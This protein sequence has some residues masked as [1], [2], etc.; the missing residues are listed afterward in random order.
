VGNIFAMPESNTPPS[1][2]KHL[3]SRV[4]GEVYSDPV[5]LGLYA[6]DASNYQIQPLA[7]VVPRGE[8]DV[9]AAI[10]L[11]AEEGVAMLPRGGGTSLAGQAVA[12]AMVIDF[13][14]Y[15]NRILEVCAEER[16]ARV[17]PGLV[18]DELNAALLPTG[19]HFA[20]DPATGSRANLGGMMGTNAS[21]MRSV[22]YGRTSDHVLE[23]RVLLADGSEHLW[24]SL[25]PRD[26]ERTI[27][28]GGRTGELLGSFQGIIRRH[29][30]EIRARYP[31]I[32]RCVAG[33]SLDAFV[34]T[35]RWNLSKLMV[36]SEGTLASMVEAKVNLEPLP[37][38]SCLCVA[39]FG[40]LLE[41]IDAVEPI[42]THRPSAVEL[43]DRVTLNL[44]R[45]N[46]AVAAYCDALDGDPAAVLVVEF[47]GHDAAETRRQA[48]E[49]VTDL[50]G[51]GQGYAFPI[52]T[53]PAAQARI[54][55]LRK[56][57]LGILLALKGKRKPIPFM[58][59]AAVPVAVL[60]K[61]IGQVQ[62]ICRRHG[63]DVALYA[64]ASV[65]LIHVRPILD[66]RQP[67]DIER[68]KS[69]ADEAFEL[70]KDYGG[71]WSGEH[72]D[73]LVRSPFLERFYG[74]RL[75]QAFRE[76]KRLF[77]PRGLMNP[78]HI[79]DPEPMDH[80]LR[81]GPDYRV[82]EMP[83][84]Y[85]F[86][87]EGGFTEA[88]HLCNGVG[89]CRKTL[90]GTMCPSY[91]ATRDEAHS[92]R[93]R[94]N[95]LRLAMSGQLGPDGMTSRA[96]YDVLALCLSC[97]ACKT[98]CPSNV[99]MA[100]LKGEFM[101]GYHDRHGASLRDRLTAGL[102]ARSARLAGPWAPLV[103]RLQGSAPFRWLLEQTAGFSRRRVAPPYAREPFPDWFA[104][105]PSVP[106]G[107]AEKRVV[108][109]DDTY[110]N[111]FEPHIGQSAVALLESC[112]YSVTLARAG[113]CQ[114]P[115]LS[116]GFLRRAARDGTA[117]LR[118]LDRYIQ[119]G[120]K[121]LVCE[122]SCA[123]ALTDDLP[124][125]AD[126]PALGERMRGNVLMLDV[127]LAR[128]IEAGRCS[129]PLAS[130]ATD[131]LI[132]GH[133]HQKAL[134]GTSA[135]K[136]VLDRIPGLKVSEVDSG[137]CGM[138]GSFGYEE[139]HVEL[140]QQV[141]ERRLFPALRA[142]TPGTQVIA[143][144]FSCRHQIRDFTGVQARHF[145]ELVCPADDPSGC[146]AGRPSIR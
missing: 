1:F 125:L 86:R 146:G 64:H 88:V 10:A 15:M 5:T 81:F 111:Y 112:G 117:T 69:I 131:I 124:D 2:S 140:S 12:R 76:V 77:D 46:P 13:S 61:Y 65:G 52:M 134:Y 56:S 143:C 60:S 82:P 49:M 72:G 93:G 36:G 62:D 97:K 59:D 23:S 8:D 106:E 80:H 128:E 50:K 119:Q 133:C 123:S 109:F 7:V 99:D 116:R 18:R 24:T 21:G 66:L 102:P 19:L 122:P 44:A 6:T 127:F 28:A 87:E 9:R 126:D 34:G 4:R 142:M 78:G 43:L 38:A 25:G 107:A 14:K 130:G 103:N 136:K 83:G 48:G 113:C 121:I 17:Q 30:D 137:C 110:I 41:A 79:I 32:M 31:K 139:E 63:V 101:Q 22:R 51:R 135:M 94:A 132:H 47:S 120:L 29:E 67:A 73:G 70:V 104:R 33:Y 114:R 68:M 26:L 100:K 39:H 11:A 54:W 20:P 71:S 129:V 90:G 138:A 141:G 27:A 84:S 35:D 89:A 108:L 144:G 75:Y 91:M 16:W 85:H 95:A 45:G 37:T 98:E 3:R 55:E 74:P 118:N 96:L 92:T 42:L 58:E 40:D 53:E 105:R 57:G 145:V 115:R